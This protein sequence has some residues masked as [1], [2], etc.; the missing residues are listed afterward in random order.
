MTE[1][2]TA[3]IT[4]ITGQDGQYLA[5]YLLDRG[6]EVHGTVRRTSRG[7]VALHPDVIMH[8]A[9]MT[10]ASSLQAVL[11][12]AEWDEI[13]NLAAMTDVAASFALPDYVANV[14][15]L[16]VARLLES[17]RSL[18]PS[19]RILQASTSE[20]FGTSSPPQNERTPMR[21]Q[22]PYAA[23]K[24]YAHQMCRIYRDAYKMAISTTIAFNH[25]SPRRGQ[26]FVTRKITRGLARIRTGQQ[27][28][29][30]LGNLSAKRDWGHAR[31]YVRAMHSVL[32]FPEPQEFVIATGVSRTVREF[33]DAAASHLDMHL[34]WKGYGMNELGVDDRGRT[35]V[36]VDPKLFR[37]AEVEELE[38]DA[39]LA[40]ELLHWQ[41]QISFHEMVADMVAN[42]V[43]EVQ[44][45]TE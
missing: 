16:G 5:E 7:P 4:G 43:R 17:A 19:P 44:R 20:M 21:P 3:L 25:E 40:H 42:D 31:D 28:C 22:S 11:Q 6:Y 12:Q 10:D 2:R 30:T 45:E 15:G 36:C 27:G 29:L 39:T 32:Q 34:E 23:A 13:Y 24:L 18:V 41:P 38:G 9:D 1:H 26:E 8:Y 35:I 33:V 14:N 37:P